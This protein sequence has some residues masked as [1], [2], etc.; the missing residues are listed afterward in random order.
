MVDAPSVQSFEVKI[1]KLWKYHPITIILL[2]HLY[3]GLC[4]L[5]T[6]SLET[7]LMPELAQ[8]AGMPNT[9]QK[10][11]CTNLYVCSLP[12]YFSAKEKVVR[13]DLYVGSHAPSSG[14]NMYSGSVKFR[15]FSPVINRC[16]LIS[17]LYIGHLW[18]IIRHHIFGFA[19][20]F[21]IMKKTGKKHWLDGN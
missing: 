7:I 3:Y 4:H 14:Q 21:L 2:H 10:R 9:S 20:T 12:T 13:S 5:Y 18:Y 11:T 16:H 6:H 17:P 1:D 8:E 15:I 19:Q